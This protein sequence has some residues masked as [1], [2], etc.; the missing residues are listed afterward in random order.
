M[1]QFSTEHFHEFQEP[2]FPT[3]P[4]SLDRAFPSFLFIIIKIVNWYRSHRR[5]ICVSSCDTTSSYEAFQMLFDSIPYWPK[6]MSSSLGI[7][8]Q[9]SV[10]N[11][12]LRK[13]GGASSEITLLALRYTS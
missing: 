5:S 13:M 8:L 4:F 1:L 3:H 7:L 9:V 2:A 11:L 12:W 10:S 6:V